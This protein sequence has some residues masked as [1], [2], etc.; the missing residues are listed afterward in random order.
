[1]YYE[2]KLIDGVLYFRSEPGGKWEKRESSLEVFMPE[3]VIK[4]STNKPF[5]C[6]KHG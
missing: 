1:M 3:S 6:H 5:I 2:E 4:P